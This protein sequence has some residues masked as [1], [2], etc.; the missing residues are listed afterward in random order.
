MCTYTAN[1][2]MVDNLTDPQQAAVL[3]NWYNF[4]LPFCTLLE[5]L[6][7][8]LAIPPGALGGRMY[9]WGARNFG[10]DH[11]NR[12]YVN[13]LNALRLVLEAGNGLAPTGRL[14][15]PTN[16]PANSPGRGGGGINAGGG[17]LGSSG[18]GPCLS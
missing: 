12:D 4:S 2:R 13:T 15:T 14:V 11:Q 18:S 3:Q 1:R 8:H 6:L 17:N 5:G 7:T 16:S 9:A 10:N